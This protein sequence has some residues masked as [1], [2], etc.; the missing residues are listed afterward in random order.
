MVAALQWWPPIAL[1]FRAAGSSWPG[2]TGPVVCCVSIV[3]WSQRPGG[4]R[5]EAREE[6]DLEAADLE[7]LE[8]AA[9]K[10]MPRRWR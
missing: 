8:T 4:K 9:E 6:V 5:R 2:T 1:L 10:A 3:R 7:D